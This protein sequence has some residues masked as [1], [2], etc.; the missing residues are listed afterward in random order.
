MVAF[1][2]ALGVFWAAGILSGALKDAMG[3]TGPIRHP[4]DRCVV[5]WR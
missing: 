4:C 3:D 1:I 2:L 5:K